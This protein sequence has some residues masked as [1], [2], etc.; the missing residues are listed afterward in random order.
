VGSMEEARRAGTKQAS[1]AEA[2]GM[3]VTPARIQELR[4]LSINP[5]QGEFVDANAEFVGARGD[6]IGNDAVE[7]D[8]GEGE[9]KDRKD[10]EESRYRALLGILL[11]AS[12]PAF[13]VAHVLDL[14]VSV[15]LNDFG[16][17]VVQK[18]HGRDAGAH[19]DL[20]EH[21]HVQG[22]G[23]VDGGLDWVPKAVIECV[24]HD[25]NDL[26]PAFVFRKAGLIRR[27]ALQI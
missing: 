12:D 22:V 3:R 7:P 23:H 1:A 6:R 15:N 8:N 17:N 18:R 20:R 4:E 9:S 14:L 21:R 16:A 11:K 26:Q 27:L 19:Q 5:A 13:Q 2:I 25:A 24:R 10:S